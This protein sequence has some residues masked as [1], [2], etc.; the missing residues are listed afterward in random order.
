[1]GQESGKMS[2]NGEKYTRFMTSLTKK[3]KHKN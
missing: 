2:Q 1:L 3:T